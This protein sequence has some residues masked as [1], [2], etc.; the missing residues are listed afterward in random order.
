MVEDKIELI[1]EFGVPVEVRD[2]NLNLME[3][4]IALVGKASTGNITE[5]SLEY[6]RIGQFIPG[7][8]VEVGNLV[9]NK[10]TKATYLVLA[11]MPEVVD[12]EICAIIARFAEC[13][14]SMSVYNFEEDADENGN[15]YNSRVDKLVHLPVYVK[16]TVLDLSGTSVG[17]LPTADITIIAPSVDIDILD[18]IEVDL[19]NRI[20]KLKVKSIDYISYPGLCILNVSIDTRK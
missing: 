11:H 13:N 6:H 4:T 20:E 15:I 1:T 16:N 17:S 10:I 18:T 5:T 19:V 12:N 8:N 3:E 9:E 7:T 14:S 2:S